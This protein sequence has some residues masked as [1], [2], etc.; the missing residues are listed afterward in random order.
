MIMTTTTTTST[1][2]TMT[3]ITTTCIRTIT[4][5]QVVRRSCRMISFATKRSVA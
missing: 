5:Q 1:I 2:M 3:M 4:R